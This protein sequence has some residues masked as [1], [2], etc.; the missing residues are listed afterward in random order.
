[1][2]E[3]PYSP[4][5]RHQLILRDLLAVD[6]TVLANERTFLAYIRTALAFFLSGIT[7]LKFFESMIIRV[8]GI[9]FIPLGVVILIIGTWRFT[10]VQ[11]AI[12]RL[13]KNPS[14][15]SGTGD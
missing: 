6:R 11:K 10:H 7:I 12:G 2:Q 1:M 8:I 4:F 3:D 15:L 9:A 14:Q 13:R 5:E